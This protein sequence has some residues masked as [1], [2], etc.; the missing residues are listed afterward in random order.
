MSGYNLTCALS[1]AHIGDLRA[2]NFRRA[3]LGTSSGTSSGT[4]LRSIDCEMDT[5]TFQRPVSFATDVLF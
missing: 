4:G 1:I 5:K 3:E 2:K